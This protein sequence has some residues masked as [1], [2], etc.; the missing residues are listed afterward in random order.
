MPL[1][2]F[3]FI[4]CC[5]SRHVLSAFVE[6]CRFTPLS[7]YSTFAYKNPL[8]LGEHFYGYIYI[9]IYR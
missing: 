4:I 6:R 3:A 7:Y 5:N 9:F 1:H 2:P 8:L